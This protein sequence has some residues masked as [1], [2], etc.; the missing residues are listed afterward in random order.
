MHCAV[1]EKVHHVPDDIT[2][3]GAVAET[4]TAESSDDIAPTAECI[5]DSVDTTAASE[6]RHETSLQ[7]NT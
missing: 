7:E 5:G 3:E 6:Q 2:E 4:P 1:C